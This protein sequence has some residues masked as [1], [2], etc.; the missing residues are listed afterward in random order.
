M[1]KVHIAP[2][3]SWKTPI[4]SD[5]I[6]AETIQLGQVSFDKQDIYWV[7][8]R[9]SE[10]GRSVI[11]R[12]TPDG[13]ITDMTPSPLN[14]RTRVHEYGGGA[15]MVYDGTLYFSNFA[16]QRV[17]RQPKDTEPQPVTPEGKDFRYADG[18]FDRQRQRLI[19]VREDHTVSE[20]E[21]VNTLVSLDPETNDGGE[22]LVSGNDFYSS[23]RI[24]P[25]GRHLAWICWNHPNMPWDGTELWV[26]TFQEDGSLEDVKKIAGGQT[27]S[28]FQPEW[29]PDGILYFVSDRTGWWNLY[30]WQAEQIEPVCEMK[31]EFGKP[32]W[33]FGR[34]TYSFISAKQII[35]CYNEC[36]TW[37]LANLDVETHRLE[38]VDAPYTEIDHVQAAGEYVC[39]TA[40]SPTEVSS[41]VLFDFSTKQCDVLR[42]SSSLEV[43]K[44]YL[45]L[46]ETVEFSTEHNQTA[47]GFFY[48]PCNKEYVAS[49]AE[50]PP[51]IVRSHGG[52]TSATSS[53]LNFGIQYWTSRGFAVL[54]V[55][56]GGSTGY[57]R[58]Y[59]ERLKEQWGIVDVDDCVNGAC[60]LVN[61]GKVD[62]KRLA[63]RGGS[64]GGYTTL[65]ALAFRD[66][67]QAG[68][69]YFGVSDAVA[70]AEETHKFESRYLDSLIGPYPEQRDVYLERSPIH[71]TDQLSCPVIFFQGLEDEVVPPNQS[72]TMYEALRKKGIPVAYVTYKGEQHGFRQAKNIKHSFDTELY[73]Y[74]KIFNFDI[75]DSVEPVNIENL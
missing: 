25:D 61:T 35:C 69:S 19:Y 31:A 9:P 46:P 1:A 52:P 16:D 23:P 70:L 65:C 11:V 74:S 56:Y 41:V 5:M 4:T 36:G 17:Y 63:I 2:Y 71:F 10:G 72:E 57:G 33:I 60:Y 14:V 21:A 20:R 47:F 18:V 3:G 55:N 68:A 7:E 22:V 59:R 62:R 50:L 42:R 44:E 40:G 54:D 30:R 26:G 32:H 53:T 66:V 43:D 15:F 24:S 48:A 73:F 39:F 8:M 6:V 64:A 29:S 13:Q 37:N 28:I 45:S 34:S 58:A 49:D 38:S 75:A 12:R 27:K 67:F 51:L